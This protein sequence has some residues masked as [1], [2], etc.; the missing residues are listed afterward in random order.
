MQCETPFVLSQCGMR[1]P[2]AESMRYESPLCWVNAIWDSPYANSMLLNWDSPYAES[3][4]YETPLTL[5]QRDMR[6]PFLLVNA[7]WDPPYAKSM[8]YET[9]PYADSMLHETPTYAV[10]MRYETPIMPSQ[11][12]MSL[13]LCWVIMRLTLML[14]QCFMRLPLLWVNAEW[15]FLNA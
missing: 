4:R 15:A 6:L 12:G 1:L 9:P 2:C 13:P 11:C 3:M 14:I 5:S 10:S 7:I 8:Q